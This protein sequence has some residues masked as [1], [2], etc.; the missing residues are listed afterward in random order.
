MINTSTKSY[1]LHPLLASV[2]FSLVDGKKNQKLYA[3]ERV[4]V[5]CL[6]HL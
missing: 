5:D 1:Q 4:A 2:M 3:A 6:E